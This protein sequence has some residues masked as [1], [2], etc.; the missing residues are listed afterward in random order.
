MAIKAK[1]RIPT[2]YQ[3]VAYIGST[4]DTG[5][6]IDTGVEVSETIFIKA[7]WSFS[8]LKA[9]QTVFGGRGP[10]FCIQR[11]SNG[12]SLSTQSYNAVTTNV[13]TYTTGEIVETEFSPTKIIINGTEILINKGTFAYSN[14]T[15]WLFGK[16]NAGDT[17]IDVKGGCKIYCCRIY[18]NDSVIRDFIPCV[19]K[20][21]SK[22]GMYDTVTKQFFTNTG[23]GEFI[24][25]VA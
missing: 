23:S 12:N 2:E 3:E 10:T 1:G 9:W 8:E 11:Y 13:Y 5:Q 17:A 6:Y 19:R 15:V 18:E 4:N 25:P 16:K 22:P 14:N 7:K 20:S 24:V 21:D